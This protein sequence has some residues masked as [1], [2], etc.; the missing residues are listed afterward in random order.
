MGIKKA[1]E[2]SI[3]E[4]AAL[5]I[6]KRKAFMQDLI[7]T[8]Y[9]TSQ[10]YITIVIGGSYAAFFTSWAGIQSSLPESERFFSIILM[11]MSLIFFLGWEIF[12]MIKTSFLMKEQVAVIQA[13]SAADFEGLI[14][15]LI[16]KENAFILLNT[17]VWPGILVL[18]II[19]AI[20]GIGI[21]FVGTFKALF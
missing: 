17:K 1:I 20:L 4:A 19:P 12:K 7:V 6:Q 8:H 15:K 2:S 21:F 9:Q 10:T 18:T 13:D 3:K 16:K 5:D 11:L 14:Q